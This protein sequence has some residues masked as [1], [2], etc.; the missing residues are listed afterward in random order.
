MSSLKV[1]IG[2]MPKHLSKIS[3]FGGQY[4]LTIP[5]LLIKEMKWKGVEYVFLERLGK[6][7]IMIRRFIDGESL[8]TERKK[9]RDGAD[10]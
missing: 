5:K 8:R 2:P 1:Y 9:D 10:R 3:S 4:R 6:D 7:D